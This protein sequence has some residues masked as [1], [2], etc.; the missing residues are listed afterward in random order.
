M[1]MKVHYGVQNIPLPLP[2]QNLPLPL[3]LMNQIKPLHVP[4]F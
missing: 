2:V 4:S 1:K 3:P